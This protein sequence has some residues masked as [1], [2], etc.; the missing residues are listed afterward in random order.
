M[1]GHA[2]GEDSVL[3]SLA[4]P[5][6]Q[7]DAIEWF[8][9]QLESELTGKGLALIRA[10]VSEL[11]YGVLSFTAAQG[12]VSVYVLWPARGNKTSW[13]IRTR[14]HRSWLRRLLL[15]PPP[16]AAVEQLERTRDWIQRFL[17]THDAQGMRW[18]S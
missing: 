14:Y 3:F 16:A 18:K 10:G 11:S 12:H 6:G 2:S 5:E 15:I 9:A 1:R 17:I 8:V 7:G 4:P 13:Q